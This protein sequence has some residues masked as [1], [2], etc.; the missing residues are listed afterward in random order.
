MVEYH[1]FYILKNTWLKYDCF[2]SLFY[3]CNAKTGVMQLL[4]D[5]TPQDSGNGIL[6]PLINMPGLLNHPANS[7]ITLIQMGSLPNFL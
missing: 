7:N 2:D 4:D 1:V 6:S 5:F 3:L